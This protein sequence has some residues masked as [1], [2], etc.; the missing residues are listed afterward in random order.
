MTGL[1]FVG[2]CDE[3]KVISKMLKSYFGLAM[4]SIGSPKDCACYKSIVRHVQIR[5]G[6]ENSANLG[7]KIR[8]SAN[9]WGRISEVH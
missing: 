2:F 5:F 7:L 1:L 3:D 8:N 6:F 9:P 4:H